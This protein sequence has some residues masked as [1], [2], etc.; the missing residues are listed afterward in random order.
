MTT[1][2]RCA[3][4]LA[5][6][7]VAGCA[8]IS[9]SGNW[10]DPRFAGPAFRSLLVVA[11]SDAQTT[12]RVVEDSISNTLRQ[13]GVASS[14]SYPAGDNVPPDETARLVAIP[15]VQRSANRMS[16]DGIVTVRL[17]RIAHAYYDTGPTVGVG[18]GGGSGGWGGWS[19]AGIGVSFPFGGSTG[20]GKATLSIEAALTSVA[21]RALVWSATYS[22]DDPGN[23]GVVADRISTR[24]MADMREAGVI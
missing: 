24:I 22:M 10:R 8:G 2:R 16:A 6:A 1:F 19:G 21:S 7:A 14:A 23:A 3:G 4:A 13:S 17:L 20:A 5:L 15:S 12:R 18:V 11:A 9:Q